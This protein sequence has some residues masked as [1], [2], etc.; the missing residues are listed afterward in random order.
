MRLT[1]M[2][3]NTEKQKEVNEFAEWILNIGEGK[4]TS[5]EG[6]EWIQIP[7]IVM[8][9]NDSKWRLDSRERK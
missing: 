1:C 7:R 6:E 5:D 4:T 3:H 9:P 2:P 8:S